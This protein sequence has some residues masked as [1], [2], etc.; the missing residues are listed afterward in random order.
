AGGARLHRRRRH[1]MGEGA[2]RAP[3]RGRAADG[4]PPRR[5]LAV[6]GHAARAE[7]A[8][9]ALG[10]R[11]RAVEGLAVRVLV[12]GQD[13]YVGCLL[14]PLLEAAGHEVVGLDAGLYAGCA[15][16]PEPAV[17]PSIGRDIRDVSADQVAGIDAVAHLAGI[18]NDPL[19]DL[20]PD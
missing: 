15:L 14:V 10:L 5:L 13:G 18:S 3:V 17:V 12:T 8:G 6:H 4:V 19:G 1:G 20:N 2:A 7:T 16:G 11:R 9:A